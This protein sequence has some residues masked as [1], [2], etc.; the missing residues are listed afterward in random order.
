ML[1]SSENLLKVLSSTNPW[2][3]TGRITESFAKPTKRFAYFEGMRIMRHPDIRRIVLLTGARRTGKSTIMYQMI[4]TLL[5]QDVAPQRI[6]YISFDHPLLKLCRFDAILDAFHQTLYPDDDVYYFFD[7]IQYAADWDTWLKT[8]YDT[9]PQCKA[10]ATGSASSVLVEKTQESGVGRWSVLPIP[11]LTFY[12]YCALLHIETP[13]LAPDLTPFALKKLSRQE[14]TMVFQKLSALQRHFYR[15]LT[16]GGFP[17]PALSKDDVFSQRVM[18]ED[19]VDKVLKRDIPSLYNIRSIVDLERIFLYLCYHSSNIINMDAIA[20]ELRGVTRPTV[21]KYIRYLESANLIYVS[22]PIDL[23][24]KKVLKAQ[25]KIYI[26]DAAIR[27][28][29]VMQEDLLTNPTEMGIMAETAVYKHIASFYS[30]PTADIGYYRKSGKGG[31]I[32]IVV[33]YRTH[34]ILVDVKYREQYSLDEKSLIVSESASAS[35]TLVVTKRD[36]D[37]GE[38]QTGR[39]VYR[40]PTHAFLYLLGHAEKNGHTHRLQNRCG[41]P[42]GA[43]AW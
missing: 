35:S 25:P 39:G 12:E 40:I 37:F 11:T 24:G 16:V 15:Y 31:E 4:D 7:E 19:V 28:A 13:A 14:Q 32:D 41:Q 5:R 2:W 36:D 42:S 8:L 3:K 23:R 33:T 10:V 30:R 34:R 22:K 6:V 21:E 17:E 18:R 20:K 26:A 29:I 38:L 43:A 1:T 9:N 27:N